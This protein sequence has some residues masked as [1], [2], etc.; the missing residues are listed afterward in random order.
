M[1]PVQIHS[2]DIFLSHAHLDKQEYVYPL[3]D[4][5]SRRAI[6][7][8]MDEAQIPPGGSIIEAVDT[9]LA[10][11]R[12]VILFVTERFI[13]RNFPQRELK[14]ALSR[15]IRSGVPSV[16]PILAMDQARYFRRY[17]LLEDT[18]YLDWKD[19]PEAIADKIAALFRRKPNSDWHRCHP[20]GYV[21]PVWVRVLHQSINTGQPHR[22]TLRWGRFIIH[23]E[24]LP[25][26]EYPRSYHHTKLIDD[27]R[28]L[29]ASI[30]PPSIITFGTGDP[31][32]SNA[33]DINDGWIR[34]PGNCPPRETWV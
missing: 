19:G 15:D 20:E 2:L 4:A 11:A 13:E 12:Y 31:P 25:Q 24:F 14:A 33:S 16:I 8:W 26:S 30:E 6:S 17:P 10:G 22:L 5:L 28:P 21:G 1:H 23:L 7:Y 9:G 3:A 29:L 34:T 32:D 18:Q 27:G